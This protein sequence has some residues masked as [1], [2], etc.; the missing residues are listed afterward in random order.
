MTCTLYEVLYSNPFHL[1]VWS[2]FAAKGDLLAAK[3]IIFIFTVH[4]KLPILKQREKRKR[5]LTLTIHSTNVSQCRC[6]VKEQGSIIGNSLI[7]VSPWYE[8][9]KILCI[10]EPMWNHSIGMF[11]CSAVLFMW[12]VGSWITQKTLPAREQLIYVK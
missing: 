5:R 7:R 12:L 4:F 8:F 2:R 3:S 6:R 11:S 10:S 1:S 9:A